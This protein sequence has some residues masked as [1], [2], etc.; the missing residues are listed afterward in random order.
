MALASIG[1]S[2]RGLGRLTTGAAWFFIIFSLAHLAWVVGMKWGAPTG[3]TTLYQTEVGDH[4]Y[5]AWGLSYEGVGG[6]LQA[7][8][9]AIMVLAAATLS[10]VPWQRARR[11][12]HVVLVI[13]AAWWAMSLG[14][15]ALRDGQLD[16]I[17]QTGL[18]TALLGCTI[19]R[20]WRG[21]TPRRVAPA[22]AA[23]VTEAP[24]PNASPAARP[25]ARS[26]ARAAAGGAG[27]AARTCRD[28]ARRVTA[29]ER[30]RRTTARTIAWLRSH[31]VVVSRG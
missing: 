25:S 5:R 21:C 8:G 1:T 18:L 26:L 6:L 2:R 15:L 27:R 11:A 14:G 31:G 24:Q 19:H 17:A 12:G 10:V 28:V 30:V 29:D 20:A 3:L 7:I 13:W 9:Q 23:S 16:T 22:P 4:V